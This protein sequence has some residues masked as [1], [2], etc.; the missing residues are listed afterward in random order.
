MITITDRA[1]ARPTL[2]SCQQTHQSQLL[3]MHACHTAMCGR[4]ASSYHTLLPHATLPAQSWQQTICKMQTNAHS[5]PIHPADPQP[6][7]AA[8]WVKHLQRL[9]LEHQ[10]SKIM[11]P[12]RLR[13]AHFSG[14]KAS[15]PTYTKMDP[16]AR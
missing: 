10:A 7:Q 14:S 5:S 1:T 4:L 11:T 12:S 8:A 2:V 16:S 6:C 13:T 3:S 9:I 15:S